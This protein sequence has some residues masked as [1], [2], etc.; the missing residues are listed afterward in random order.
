MSELSLNDFDLRSQPTEPNHP[1]QPIKPSQTKS[2]PDNR[3]PLC[4]QTENPRK[5]LR[6]WPDGETVEGYFCT[7]YCYDHMWWWHC[8]LT[9]GHIVDWFPDINTNKAFRNF[10]QMYMPDQDSDINELCIQYGLD[11]RH[12]DY[13]R[14]KNDCWGVL[15]EHYRRNNDFGY[16]CASILHRL[17]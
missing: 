7:T 2:F 9:I 13:F 3:C 17:Q 11:T 4:G 1:P 16:T 8:A 5:F 12:D 6:Y 15:I 10:Q 14:K